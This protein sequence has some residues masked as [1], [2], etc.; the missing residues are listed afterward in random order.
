MEAD[1]KKRYGEKLDSIAEAYLG[2]VERRGFDPHSKSAR[3]FAVEAHPVSTSCKALHKK[4]HK[5]SFAE[6]ALY[7]C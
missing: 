1:A 6:A 5:S 2:F 3:G 4:R 7:L